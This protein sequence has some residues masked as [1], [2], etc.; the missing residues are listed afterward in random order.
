MNSTDTSPGC[1]AEL[2]FGE[3]LQQPSPVTVAALIFIITIQILTFPFTVVLNTLVMIAVKMKSRLRAHK[4]NMLLAL[5]ASTDFTVGVIIQPSFIAV[6]VMFLQDEPSGY[7]FLAVLRPVIGTLVDASLFHLA[8]ISS[9]RYLAMKH[10]FAYTTIV[11]E[12]RLLV[13]S[14]LVWLLSVILNVLFFVDLTVFVRINNTLI[15]LCIAVIV[16]CHVTVYRET[17][18]HEWQVA[19]QQVTQEAREQFQKEKKAFKLTGIILAV[20]ILCFIPIVSF[21]IATF[22]Y[23]SE[24][25]LETVYVFSCSAMSIVLLN[26]LINPV[27]Y[28]IRLRQFRVAFIELICRTVNIA[29]AEETEMRVFGAPNGVV[30]LQGERGHGA[31]DDQNVEQGNVISHNNNNDGLTQQEN[32]VVE[33]PDNTHHL[34]STVTS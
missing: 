31:T 9:E 21:T 28:S 3:R 26:S 17:R 19:A 23:G 18:R 7:C 12:V 13:A 29:E 33:Q 24:M 32:S 4:S 34:P 15:G 22:R 11:T 6:L 16:F 2:L 27:I 1:E 14:G 8:L 25:S 30:R 10:P 20:L 5:L